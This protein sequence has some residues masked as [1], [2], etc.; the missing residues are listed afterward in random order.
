MTD[1]L[2]AVTVVAFNPYQVLSPK[3]LGEW[4]ISMHLRR[5]LVLSNRQSIQSSQLLLLLS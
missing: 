2:K 3:H 1:E 5:C 4:R